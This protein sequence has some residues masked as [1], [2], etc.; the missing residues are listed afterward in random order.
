MSAIGRKQAGK[1]HVDGREIFGELTVSGAETLLYLRDDE[2]FNDRTFSDGCIHGTLHDLEMVSLFDCISSGVGH[3]VRKD[4]RYYFA[5]VFPHHVISGRQHISP[6]D[7]TIS[8]IHFLIDD[9]ARL[10]YDFD[11]FGR[12]PKPQ[13]HIE[14]LVNAKTGV[15]HR[16]VKT[17]PEPEIVYFSGRLEIFNVD[18]VLGNVSAAHNPVSGMGGPEGIFIKNSIPV[19]LRFA[20]PVN[21]DSAFDG[22]LSLV[23][24]FELLVGRQQNIVDVGLVVG[25]GTS[26]EHYLKVEWSLAPTRPAP[27]EERGP[28]PRD[29]LLSPI[30]DPTMFG[31]VLSAYFARRSVW[32]TARWRFAGKFNQRRSYDVDRLVAMANV[33]DIL[34]DSI[35]PV[36][37]PIADDLS[38]ARDEAKALFEALP[39]TSDRDSVLGA[40]GRIGK[41]S[42]KRKIS[43]RVKLISDRASNRFPELAFV[44]EKA[45]NCRNYFVHGSKKDFD[46]T[47]DY[48]LVWFFVDTLE[49]VFGASDLIEAGWEVATWLARGSMMSHPFGEY[50]NQ[51]LDNLKRLKRALASAP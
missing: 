8:A 42:L 21:F 14:A 18:T 2:P 33:F 25:D 29:I 48:P 11:A 20:S 6:P 34:P 41:L 38:K 26:Y 17:G 32:N 22:M 45:V 39:Q 15:I 35:F 40:L 27:D 31:N 13:D 24:Y 44:T 50:K 12:V 36:G 5:K 30:D 37:P 16:E 46:Y 1:F 3:T 23:R 9:A 47:D 28:H 19:T 49:F 4:Q 10:F 7:G 43:A 51:Y